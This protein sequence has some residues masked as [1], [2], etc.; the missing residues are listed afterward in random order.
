MTESGFELSADLPLLQ[1]RHRDELV[2]GSAISIDV[3]A[4]RGYRSVM[5]RQDL[6]TAGFSAA[7]MQRHPAGFLIPVW[8]VE[9]V[10][11]GFSY[12]PDVPRRKQDGKPI[13]YEHPKGS[14]VRLDVHPQV[15]PLI[16][17]PKVEKWWT[18]GQKK[19]DSLISHG[20]TALTLHGVWGMKGTNELGGKTV[21]ADLDHVAVN[22]CRCVIVYDNDVMVN[23]RVQAALD[24]L[25]AI[26]MNRQAEVWWCRLPW[27]PGQPKVGVDDF[28][29]THSVEELREY[30][31]LAT[32]VQPEVQFFDSDGCFVRRTTDRNGN[33]VEQRLC[34][35]TM[36]IVTDIGVDDGEDQQRTYTIRLRHRNG[37]L[38]TT[39]ITAADWNDTRL[40]QKVLLSAAGPS[41]IVEQGQ[42][43][44]VLLAAQKL[45]EGLTERQTYYTHTGW[46]ETQGGRR[47][48]M[49]G[50]AVGPDGLDK[51]VFVDVSGPGVEMYGVTW[52]TDEE[53]TEAGWEALSTA[54]SA[55]S[56][57]VG[58]PLL[59]HIV[60]A[61]LAWQMPVDKPSLLHLVGE[62]G[63]FKTT[64]ATLLLNL[65]G[66]FERERPP[67]TWTSTVNALERSA[68]TLKDLP[69]LIDDFKLANIRRSED[70]VRFIQ[71]YGDRT[72]RSRM[73]ADLTLRRS[74][75]PRGVLFSTGEDVPERE[76]SVLGR[77]LMISI[78][79]GEVDRAKLSEA[80]KLAGGLRFVGARW[81]A[82]LARNWDEAQRRCRE[83]YTETRDQ[84]VHGLVST[85]GRIAVSCAQLEIAFDLFTDFLC[86]EYPVHKQEITDWVDALNVAL[87]TAGQTQGSR[88][89]EERQGSS[90]MEWVLS[91]LA[92]DEIRLNLT[93]SSGISWL[94]GSDAPIAGWYDT[95]GVW[96]AAAKIWQL[97][98]K[99]VRQMGESLNWTREAV[100]RQ[101]RS[102]GLLARV[103]ADATT[104]VKKVAGAPVRCLEFSREMFPFEERFATGKAAWND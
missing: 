19:G 31:T 99:G 36:S 27:I 45:S 6:L 64:Y 101:L 103:G 80:Q 11:A 75:P 54:I 73:K 60:A 97:Y 82:W 48:I 9:G 49:P 39:R 21:L 50:N 7:Q 83:T 85:H 94:G 61:P 92:T 42:F 98:A 81:L 26:L 86:E 41:F 77:M 58:M 15:K 79:P 14:H 65:F 12:K 40:A 69:V 55:A 16:G 96:L 17:D 8:T 18:E 24:R 53:E 57:R 87:M 88:V 13:K 68:F 20:L 44:A 100:W 38:V 104:V 47:F 70:M 2:V 5:G 67:L 90:F 1:Q 89:R 102:D 28:L 35:F 4:A 66:N 84:W 76:S 37:E 63:T 78:E 23:P 3:A 93:G 62:T 52:P 43:P 34:N 10:Q 56:K 30:C 46:V 29:L 72:S 51:T 33:P 32:E 71:N 22:D 25:T 59:A 91:A 74:F 95:T